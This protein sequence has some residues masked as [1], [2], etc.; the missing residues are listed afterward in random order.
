MIIARWMATM[1]KV[2]SSVKDLRGEENGVTSA[3][4]SK[5]RETRKKIRGEKKIRGRRKIRYC[6]HNK[7]DHSKMDG[8][9]GESAQFRLGGNTLTVKGN[10]NVNAFGRKKD[11]VLDLVRSAG[12]IFLFCLLLFFSCSSRT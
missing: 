7:N 4:N 8:N 3:T 1:E 12:A 6:N 9:N 10:R 2:P 11:L 5:R